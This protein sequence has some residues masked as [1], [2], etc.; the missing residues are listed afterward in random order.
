MA[1][2][3]QKKAPSARKKRTASS[4]ASTRR[5]ASD[6]ITLLKADHR[7]VEALFGQFEKTRSPQRKQELATAIC[8]ALRVHTTI[9][10]EIF[11]P[12][13][14]EAT[15]DKQIHHEAIV[16]HDGRESPQND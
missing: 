1:R 15:E 4:T 13:F 8:K 9:E 14:F 3:K 7:E 6:A 10:E 2:S 11:Y 16:E 5:S 12:A